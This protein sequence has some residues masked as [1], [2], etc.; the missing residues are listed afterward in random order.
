MVSSCQSDF[1]G[2]LFFWSYFI[3]ELFYWWWAVWAEA[4]QPVPLHKQQLQAW[5]RQRR[6]QCSAAI[7]ETQ[8]SQ[9]ESNALKYVQMLVVPTSPIQSG[10]G[11]VI[12]DALLEAYWETGFVQAVCPRWAS[13]VNFGVVSPALFHQ[14]SLQGTGTR[15]LIITATTAIICYFTTEPKFS[16]D[17][18]TAPKQ[19]KRFTGRQQLRE[20]F[21]DLILPLWPKGNEEALSFFLNTS[22]T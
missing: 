3:S 12:S 4:G 14:P 1:I 20:K 18:N 15:W 22:T 2:E 13:T 16:F 5:N 6:Q 21:W 19:R 7:R 9:S 8:P 17:P 11:A 10:V